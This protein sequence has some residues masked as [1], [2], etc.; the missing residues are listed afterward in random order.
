MR[1][2]LGRLGNW[3]SGGDAAR[4]DFEIVRVALDADEAE[5]RLESGDASGATAHEGVEDDAV[6]RG[7]ERA[8]P[9]HEGE[10][11]DCRVVVEVTAF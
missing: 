10:G 6:R 7:D 9:A 2:L 1:F 8:E 11:L 4:G 5:G 3:L